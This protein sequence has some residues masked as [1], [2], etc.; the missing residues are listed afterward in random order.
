MTQKKSKTTKRKREQKVAPRR[1][2]RAKGQRAQAADERA[3]TAAPAE[4]EERIP[5]LYVAI[6]A[7]IVAGLAVFGVLQWRGSGEGEP[8]GGETAAPGGEMSI[9]APPDVA[10]PPASAART[11][12]GL[13]SRVLREGTGTRH[14]SADSR[15]EVHYVGWTTDGQRFDSSVERGQPIQFSLSG[16]IAGWTEG[17]QLMVEGERR[18]FWIPEELAYRGRPGAPAGMLVF[19]VE[20]IRILD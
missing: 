15:V 5:P 9:E 7:L 8:A 12:S 20:L 2:P 13:A 17:V 1:A 14:P 19:D 16:V 10:A 4:R 6:G 3:D 18:R 11:A